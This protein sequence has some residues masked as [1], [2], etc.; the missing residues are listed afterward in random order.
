[1]SAPWSPFDFGDTRFAIA[2]DR[3]STKSHVMAQDIDFGDSSTGP[4]EASA[5]PNVDPEFGLHDDELARVIENAIAAGND[6]VLIA[7]KVRVA[8]AVRASGQVGWDVS[9]SGDFAEAARAVVESEVKRFKWLDVDSLQRGVD[10]VAQ[11]KRYN[12]QHVKRWA[13]TRDELTG[14]KKPKSSKGGRTGEVPERVRKEV[15]AQA[16]WHCQF[17]GC[18]E[19]LWKHPTADVVGNFSY[20]AHIIASSKDGPRGDDE[21]SKEL[22]DKAENVM[23]LCDKCHR[24]IDR[25]SP[26]AYPADRLFAMRAANIAQV[27]RLFGT[28]R[29]PSSDMIVIGGNISGQTVRFDQRRAEQAMRAYKLRPWRSEPYWF[30]YNGSEQG[31]GTVPHYWESLFDQLARSAI[32]SLRERLD[33]TGTGGDRAEVISVFPLHLMSVLALAGRLIGEARSVQLFQF[34]RN[35]VSSDK[36]DQWTWPV[37]ADEPGNEKYSAHVHREASGEAEAVLLVSLTDRI[38]ATELPQHLYEDGV[39]KLPVVEV[40][41]PNPSRSVIGHPKD[42][43]LVGKAFDTALQMLQEKWRVDLIH[44]VPIAPAT[45]CVRLGQKLQARHQSRIVFYERKTEPDGKRGAFQP[46]IELAAAYVKN[47]R[48][49]RE[50]SLL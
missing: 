9:A 14:F 29:Y 33:G 7:D 46:T 4:S 36:G 28:L 44:C 48:T 49:G 26:K 25:I 15:G 40:V 30:A 5:M 34:E 43:E 35:T 8:V 1:M 3:V 11:A 20:F 47:V 12:R 39:W 41:V 23:L 31:D 38:P 50:V 16:G 22:A 17:E 37:D 24:V 10:G 6:I 13:D 18:G 45:A 27:E 21:R 2:L 32:A 19:N 42:V